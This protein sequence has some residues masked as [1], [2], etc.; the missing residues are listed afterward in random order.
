MPPTRKGMGSANP[1][2]LTDD[3]PATPERSNWRNPGSQWGAARTPM[4][5][6]VTPGRTSADK[7]KGSATKRE[8]QTDLYGQRMTGSQSSPSKSSPAKSQR[9]KKSDG[10]SPKEKRLRRFRPTCPQAFH[11][12]HQRALTQR[13]YVLERHRGGTPEYPQEIVELTGSTGNIYHV[14]IAQQPRCTCPHAEQGNQCKHMIYVLSKVLNAPFNLTYQ[15]ALLSTE[16]QQIFA[17]APPI[18][19]AGTSD[20]DDGKR[21]PI[22]GDCPICFGELDVNNGESVVWCRAACGQNIHR[23]CF[24]MWA[25]SKAGQTT[26]PFCRSAWEGDRDL[27]DTKKIDKQRGVW[28]DGYVNIRDQLPGVSRVR[29]ESSYSRWSPYMGRSRYRHNW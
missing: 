17:N 15:L 1:I 12:V 24:G 9:K 29:D 11:D 7:R 5:Q 8:S 3:G 16:L 19:S 10:E 26:C 23:E 18:A 2:D 28:E 13:F 22:E 6:S 21:K 14:H 25:K 4:P 27:V 20:R